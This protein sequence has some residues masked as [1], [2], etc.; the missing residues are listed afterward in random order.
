LLG[1]GVKLLKS[2]Y[3]SAR[4]DTKSRRAP[5][6]LSGK[7]PF[8]FSNRCHHFSITSQ[9]VLHIPVQTIIPALCYDS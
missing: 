6:A 2:L 8:C 1:L 7:D 3:R 9:C 5:G 4:F